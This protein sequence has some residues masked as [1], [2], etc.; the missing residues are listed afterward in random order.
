MHLLS[1]CAYMVEIDSIAPIA[2][3]PKLQKLTAQST[4]KIVHTEN[5]DKDSDS[6]FPLAKV[7]YSKKSQSHK[8]LLSPVNK[9][10]ES[11]AFEDKIKKERVRAEHALKV[12]EKLERMQY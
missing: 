8:T 12:K 7:I 4:E 6:S 11:S 3:I 2:R 10:A 5:H 1:P 9:T